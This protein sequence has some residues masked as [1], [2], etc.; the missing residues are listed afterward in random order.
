MSNFLSFGDRT[1]RIADVDSVAVIGLGRFGTALALELMRTGTEVL[2]VDADEDIVQ[3]LNGQLTQVVRADATRLETLEQLDIGSFDRVVVGVG[4]DIRASV[5]TA[6]LLL[7]LNVPAVW[8]KADDEQHALILEQLGVHRVVAPEKEMGRRVAHLVRG[9]ATDYFEVEPGFAMV[10]TTVPEGLVDVT[11][12]ASAGKLP[13]SISIAAVRSADG[14]WR[15]ASAS[16]ERVLCAGDVFLIVGPTAQ[17]E[18]FA[19]LR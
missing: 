12:G 19:Q 16:Q 6:S 1:R 13:K 17:V 8:A 10:K 11:L 18:A 4:S 7:R 14:T 15:N 3:S 2:G 9:A 5:L